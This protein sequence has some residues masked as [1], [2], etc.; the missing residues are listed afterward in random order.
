MSLLES[1]PSPIP[2]PVMSTNRLESLSDG[3]FAIV[4]TLLVLDLRLPPG[5][6]NLEARLV[7]IWPRLLARRTS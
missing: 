3:V 4:I 1:I 5:H 7:A 2:R 6:G